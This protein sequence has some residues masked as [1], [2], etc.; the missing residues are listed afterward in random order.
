MYLL[1]VLFCYYLPR[2]YHSDEYRHA[3]TEGVITVSHTFYDVMKNKSQTALSSAAPE[4]NPVHVFPDMSNV[5]K[6]RKME[7]LPLSSAVSDM[8]LDSQRSQS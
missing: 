3:L 7:R 8:M 4:K 5:K 6:Q 2:R 1:S